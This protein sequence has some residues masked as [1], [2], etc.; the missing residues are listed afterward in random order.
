MKVCNV[1][2]E[3]HNLAARYFAWCCK[4]QLADRAGDHFGRLQAIAKLVTLNK[5]LKEHDISIDVVKWSE[6]AMN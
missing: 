2:D 5:R 3:L 4:F 6:E 1:K